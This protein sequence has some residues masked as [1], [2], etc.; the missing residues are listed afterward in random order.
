MNGEISLIAAVIAMVLGICSGLSLISARDGASK[1]LGIVVL[2]LTMLLA[3]GTLTT[4]NP[5]V[6]QV[7]YGGGK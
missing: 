6:R 3:Y 7:L 5:D 4:T 2:G 1:T